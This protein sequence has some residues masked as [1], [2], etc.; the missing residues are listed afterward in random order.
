VALTKCYF[1]DQ[2]KK[3]EIG[4]KFGRHQERRGA[5]IVLVGRSE[6]KRPS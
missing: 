1:G 3:N 6:G 4:R 5:D 2:I